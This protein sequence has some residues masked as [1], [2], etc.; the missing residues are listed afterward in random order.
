MGLYSSLRFFLEFSMVCIFVFICLY[1]YGTKILKYI[2]NNNWLKYYTLY[3]IFICISGFIFFPSYSN[4]SLIVNGYLV[5]LALPLVSYIFSSSSSISP[6]I[7]W[8]LYFLF[9]LSLIKYF[10]PFI[11]NMTNFSGYVSI[12]YIL[13]IF[14]PF[15][16]SK[17][18]KIIILLFV[19]LSLTYELN[20]RTNVLMIIGCFLIIVLGPFFSRLKIRSKKYIIILG[21]W[22]SLIFILLAYI[23]VFNIF[24]FSNMIDAEGVSN[25]DTRTFLYKEIT[26]HNNIFQII[27]GRSAA[28]GYYSSLASIY[29]LIS[30]YRQ[31]T[32]CGIL[33]YYLKGGLIWCITYWGLLFYSAL[34]SVSSS[35]KL[36][37]YIG[38]YLTLYWLV[39]FI[40]LQP[41]FNTWTVTLF[42]AIGFAN[43][44][45][46]RSKTN[47]ELKK[48]INA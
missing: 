12:I 29:G 13:L 2:N 38:L 8:G 9:P 47:K 32:E 41:S 28:G 3:T 31:D 45:E 22:L 24:E 17:V 36:C 33:L 26:A 14:I 19:V 1:W 37:C 18:K 43:S 10:G 48:I 40:E 35:N 30:L 34:K 39:S 42:I 23:N 46:I 7:T 6:F 5:I 44:K 15:I 4:I 25:V 27:F 16:T 21:F 20:D 11:I